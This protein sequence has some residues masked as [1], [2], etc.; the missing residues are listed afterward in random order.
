MM[1]RITDAQGQGTTGPQK[2]LK[3]SLTIPLGRDCYFT[4]SSK[5]RESIAVWRTKEVPSFFNYYLRNPGHWSG[6]GKRT[7][8]LRPVVM[9]STDWAD[10]AAVKGFVK[11]T[12]KLRFFGI[13]RQPRTSRSHVT[14]A[15]SSGLRFEVHVCTARPRSRGKW[16][17]L[18]PKT[19]QTYVWEVIC[20][21]RTLLRNDCRILFKKKRNFE[22]NFSAK[23]EV[24]GWMKT[25]MSAASYHPRNL[26]SK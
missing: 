3:K 22:D 25:N 19:S 26:S 17:T 8:D 9:C 14:R 1:R 5:P 13:S 6:P 20:L 7:F 4:W 12:L 15:L 21:F 23:T 24:S 11:E 2:V 16:F 10:P 18:H